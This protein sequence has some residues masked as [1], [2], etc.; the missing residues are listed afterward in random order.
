M[1]KIEQ[2]VR[3][4]QHTLSPTIPILQEIQQIYGYIAPEF[5]LRLSQLMDVSVAT[6]YGVVTFYSQFRL[7]PL[8]EN[9]IQICYGTACHLAGADQ[10]SQAIEH[11][12][13]TSAGSTSAD[14]K[15]SVEK[16]ACVG[17]CSLAPV[18]SVNGKIH[19]DLTA[20]QGKRII[21]KLKSESKKVET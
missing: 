9:H 8:G 14:R 7:E 10:I 15:F 16:V 5:L 18:A 13:Q 4:H 20:E 2:V 19:G 1:D 21:K 17:C 11:E 12:S 6:L 3:K